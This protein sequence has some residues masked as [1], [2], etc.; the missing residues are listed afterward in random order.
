MRILFLRRRGDFGYGPPLTM[1]RFQKAVEQRVEECK[2]A[3]KGWPLYGGEES[4]EKT[5][6]RIYGN[7]PPNW[8][9]DR[10]RIDFLN[11]NRAYKVGQ[12]VSDL[13]GRAGVGARTPETLCNHLNKMK[14][15]ALFLKAKYIY[16]S[17][18]SPD[19]FLK[20][21]TPK[22][23]FLPYAIDA[24]AFRPR[25]KKK[26]DVLFIG[27]VGGPYHLRMKLHEG[28]S[29]Y[30]KKR[31]LS[32]RMQKTVP[33]YWTALTAEKDPAYLVRSTYEEAL[34]RTRFLP[35]GSSVYRYPVIKYFEG[36]A[37]ECVV[38]ADEPSSAE[39]LGFIDGVNY[40]KINSGNWME[41]MDYYVKHV[42][43]ANEIAHN[44]RNLVLERHTVEVRAKEFIRMLEEVNE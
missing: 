18:C 28:L 30:C 33:N 2:W 42:D 44:A 11:E 4:V 39:E 34:G 3:G 6:R 27:S 12:Y 10:E 31:K 29:T 26:Y 37:S 35:F 13:H 22:N 9:I 32:L 16:G 25:E 23:H 7:D 43:E 1:F 40:V 21:L 41:K 20:N 38:L 24:Q 8:V 17:K 15:D 14:Y 36:M 19:F 5:V